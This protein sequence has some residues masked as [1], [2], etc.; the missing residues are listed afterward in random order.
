MKGT[1]MANQQ[2]NTTT[3][4]INRSVLALIYRNLSFSNTI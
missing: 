4:T 2:L 3:N 1:I